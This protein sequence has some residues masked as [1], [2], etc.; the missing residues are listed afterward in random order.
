MKRKMASAFI[1][2]EYLWQGHK[3]IL[4]ER[5][6]AGDT[7]HYRVT[8]VKRYGNLDAAKETFL[9]EIPEAR[10]DYY[11]KIIADYET[12]EK[13]TRENLQPSTANRV[14]NDKSKQKPA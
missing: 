1:I 4:L 5:P 11:E 14:T 10:R 2:A 8:T 9:Q 13:T 12:K 6:N 3:Q 7:N